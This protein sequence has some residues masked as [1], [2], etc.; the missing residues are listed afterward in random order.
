MNGNPNMNGNPYMNN[1]PN[2]N[3]YHGV[4]ERSI[5]LCILFTIITCGIYGIYWMI[6]LNDEINP[7]A[8]EP[9]ATSGGMVLLLSFVTCGIYGLYW[10][11]LLYT[12]TGRCIKHLQER[13]TGRRYRT[14]R[15]TDSSEPCC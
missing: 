13:K 3:P 2:M 8:G 7:L 10:I 12:S 5:P 11:C 14:V 1:T 9:Q 15:W 4:T 6:V